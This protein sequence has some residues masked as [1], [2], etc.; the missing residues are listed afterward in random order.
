MTNSSNITTKCDAL[1]ASA[2]LNAVGKPYSASYHPDYKM[3][4]K[5]PSVARLH[6]PAKLPM[7]GD[8]DERK[9]RAKKIRAAWQKTT[10]SII[11][12]GQ[13][14][15][16]ARDALPRGAFTTM[17]TNELPFGPRTA[18]MLMAVA[19]HPVLSNAK[20]VSL[21]PPSWGTL[22]Q[23][24]RLPLTLVEQYV[25]D[26]TITPKLERK[27]VM[28]LPGAQ[29]GRVITSHKPKQ[30]EEPS[31][32][33][34]QNL[35][36]RPALVVAPMAKQP[37]TVTADP[38]VTIPLIDDGTDDADE[39]DGPQQFWQRSLANMAGDAIALEAAWTR[40]HGA[41]WRSFPVSRDLATLAREAA[42]AWISLADQLDAR[43]AP[44]V[45][46]STAA[47]PADDGLDIPASL[48]R[49]PATP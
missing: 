35:P 28:A 19:E 18:Q 45:P 12:T 44:V 7:V 33:N 6:K 15:I 41:A 13:L 10:E 3:R 23:L 48:R 30:S 31:V 4:H 22:Y 49:E 8:E 16:A 40:Q 46:T 11:E 34:R 1:P 26:G 29:I 32:T 43:V 39:G 21:L 36:T 25:E 14:L 27:D 38:K 2:P 20:H 42:D 9:A 5:P 17:V 24:T 37:S 47:A